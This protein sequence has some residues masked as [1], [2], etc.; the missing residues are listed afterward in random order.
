MYVG[1]CVSGR[2]RK[3]ARGQG[4]GGGGLSV[5]WMVGADAWLPS[6][7]SES[8]PAW[9]PCVGWKGQ[10]CVRAQVRERKQRIG[11]RGRGTG[12]AKEEEGEAEGG[13]DVCLLACTIG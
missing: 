10:V 3:R 11:G 6:L 7:R 13:I 5:S 12:K 8:M 1:R 9:L 4:G 2:E